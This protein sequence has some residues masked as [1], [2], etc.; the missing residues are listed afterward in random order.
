MANELIVRSKLR[1]VVGVVPWR[2]AT[3]SGGDCLGHISEPDVAYSHSAPRE[4]QLEHRGRSS[5]HYIVVSVKDVERDISRLIR[6]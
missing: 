2:L 5:S 1:V 4:T 3:S 6:R